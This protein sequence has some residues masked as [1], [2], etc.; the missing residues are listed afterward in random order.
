MLSCVLHFREK[1][2]TTF[3]SSYCCRFRG[4]IPAAALSPRE[5]RISVEDMLLSTR[6]ALSISGGDLVFKELLD[7]LHLSR[8]NGFGPL[9]LRLQLKL[10]PQ[11]FF[12]HENIVI[13][14]DEGRFDVCHFYRIIQFATSVR[15]CL[16]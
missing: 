7:L 6:G 15:Q 5:P 11:R 16:L 2:A 14:V 4:V 8:S 13:I 3:R 1:T 12:L 9:K 10:R